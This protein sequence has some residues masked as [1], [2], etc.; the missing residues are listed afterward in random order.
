[1]NTQKKWG[2]IVCRYLIVICIWQCTS[3]LVKAYQFGYNPVQE[4]AFN[5]I[6]SKPAEAK[7]LIWKVFETT[8][9]APDSVH[10]LSWNIIGVYYSVNNQYEDALEAYKQALKLLP[11]THTK[12]LHIL[13]NSAITKKLLGD[14]QDALNLMYR[15]IDLA[16]ALQPADPILVVKLY[17][18]VA[19]IL[20][21]Q[22][23]Y[24]EAIDYVIEG[25][26]LLELHFPEDEL[27]LAYQRQ[28][29]ANLYLRTKNQHFAKK[30]FESVLPVFKKYEKSDAYFLSMLSMVEVCLLNEELEK[31][32]LYG[33]NAL[34][35]FQAFDNPEWKSLAETQLATVYMKQGDSLYAKRLFESAFT[36]SLTARAKTLLGITS[37][38]LEMLT[39]QEQLFVF[40]DIEYEINT[41]FSDLTTF[42]INDQYLYY[43]IMGKLWYEQKVFEKALFYF[44]NAL[45]AKETM[46]EL[47]ELDAVYEVQA[48][49]Q[50]II[51]EL[52]NRGLEQQIINKNKITKYSYSIIVLL[53]LIVI[54]LVLRAMN[55]KKLQDAIAITKDQEAIIL[56]QKLAQ[57]EKADQLKEKLL[58]EQKRQLLTSVTEKRD[59]HTSINNLLLSSDEGKRV[60]WKKELETLL[61]RQQ[62]WK[63]ITVSFKTLYPDFERRLHDKYPILSVSDI[64]FCILYSLKFSLKE[65]ASILNIEHQS[66]ITKK[67]RI[68][69]KL[70]IN[71]VELF[72]TKLSEITE[73]P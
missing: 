35:G 72:E 36:N 54:F 4:E 69:K 6:F 24:N 40:K 15:V 2:K 1:M 29:L 46:S 20:S 53:V 48:R 3:S 49:Y 70:E 9:T 11:E 57:K 28:K 61:G 52:E 21:N 59:I 50:S 55:R 41:L 18:E 45:Q 34:E 37:R 66:A 44:K 64:D 19:S 13:K 12:H 23:R 71:N 39:K 56:R 5:A 73:T 38:Y 31:A 27:N 33:R 51:Q 43:S 32:A 25:I 7:T 14:D 30:M 16:L 67:Y 63:G 60:Q 8:K 62:F 10:A 68:A 42:P 22:Y 65:I 26:E 17:G 47:T 58:A